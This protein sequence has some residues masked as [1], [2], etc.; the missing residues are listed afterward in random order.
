MKNTRQH[1]VATDYLICGQTKKK[2]IYVAFQMKRYFF[3]LK[4]KDEYNHN[5]NEYSSNQEYL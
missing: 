2:K 1:T 4:V 5:D 3:V